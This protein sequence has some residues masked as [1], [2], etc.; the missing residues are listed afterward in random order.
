MNSAEFVSAIR[1]R[2]INGDHQYYSESLESSL[3]PTDPIWKQGIQLYK[4][5]TKEQK[6]AFL[7]FL[8]L[9][10][11]NT[12]SHIFGILDGSSYL[13]GKNDD[14]VLKTE[15]SEAPINGYLQDLFWEMEDGI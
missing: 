11:A 5:M 9:V 12:V 10:Q 7:N 4:G 14:F 2:V 3:E 1:E 13:E 15:S 8:R 6:E